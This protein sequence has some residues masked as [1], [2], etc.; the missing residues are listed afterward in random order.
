MNPNFINS[1]PLALFVLVAKLSGQESPPA[2]AESP[3]KESPA[4]E[5]PK[6]HSAQEMVFLVKT[7]LGAGTAFFARM[8]GKIYLVTNYHVLKG[9]SRVEFSNLNTKFEIPVTNDIEV[10]DE[11]DLV[12]IPMKGDV[13]LD[14][15]VTPNLNASIAAY[16]NSGG[17]NVVTMTT[18]KILGVG[19]T[20]IEVSSGFISGNSGGPII[21]EGEK[22]VAVATYAAKDKGVKDW[23]IRGTRFGETRRFGVRLLNNI[24][25]TSTTLAS[26]QAQTQ[27]IEDAELMRA[28]YIRFC[29]QFLKSPFKH[30]L[31]PKVNNLELTNLSNIYNIQCKDYETTLSKSVAN[32]AEVD[33]INKQYH[34]RLCMLVETLARGISSYAEKVFILNP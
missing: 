19:P 8:N 9:S 27:A 25:W 10:A 18:G 22:V 14:L 26:F 28:E 2:P 21:D 6:S 3:V 13:G 30:H 24:K 11:L 5:L 1:I 23:V 33:T 32:A 12:R 17:M 34:G 15:N 29:T 31:K 16:G 7:N 20:E 4:T